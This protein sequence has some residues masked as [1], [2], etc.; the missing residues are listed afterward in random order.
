MSSAQFRRAGAFA[1]SLAVIS[2]VSVAGAPAAHAS[3]P[4]SG[5]VLTISNNAT[6]IDFIGDP[7]RQTLRNPVPEAM[8]DVSWSPDGSRAVYLSPDQR[9]RSIRFDGTGKVQDVVLT[10]IPGRQRAGTS[11]LGDGSGVVWAEKSDAT[12]GWTIRMGASTWGVGEEQISPYGFGKHYRNPDGGPDG[13]V[14]FQREDDDGTG[15]PTGQPAVM[16]YEP[17]AQGGRVT[18]VD[19]NGGNPAFS[20]DGRRWPSSARARSSSLI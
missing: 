11:W 7:A 8:R 12:S 9:I 18:L 10:P 6:S 13:R 15:Q 20:P 1:S 17:G 5:S 19:D 3:L 2:A 4:G 14:V 16:L